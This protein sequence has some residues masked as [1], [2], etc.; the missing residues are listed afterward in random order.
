MAGAAAPEDAVELLRALIRTACVNDGTPESGQEI[1]GV[2]VLQEYLGDLP[3]HVDVEVVE[4]AP[5]RANLIARLRGT[6][7][8][9][10]S[11]ALVGH[12]DVVPADPAGWR[13]DPFGAE[14]I[15]GEIWG[16]GAVDMLNLT[17]AMAVAFKMLA[18]SATRL[19]GDLVLAATAD[20]EAGSRYG[21]G[22]LVANRPD[23]V[24]TDAA[25]TE[26]GGGIPLGSE[27]SRR[28]TITTGQKGAAVRRV[29]LRGTSGHGSM[30][31]GIV[32]GTMLAADV[33]S[34]LAAHRT[35]PVI[36]TG[37]WWPGLL[38]SLELAPDLIERLCD[39]TTLD[40][41]LPETGEI[42]RVLHAL[43]H[44]TVSPNVVASGSK[45]NVI[46][47]EATVDLDIRLLPGQTGEDA[48]R[49]LAAALHGL[50]AGFT[51]DAGHEAPALETDRDDPLYRVLCD[52][53]DEFHP[54][55]EP[56]PLLT[57]GGNDARHYLARGLPCY[58]F[59]MFS[60]EMD[61]ATFRARFHG[62]DE[63]IDVD[64]VHLA[65]AAYR[66]IAER[67]LAP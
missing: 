38:T 27:T 35:A 21:M 47:G 48:D 40:D 23:L 19:R 34:R 42:A 58:G 14:I 50:D 12:L 36:P 24:L 30:P 20:E 60:A 57:P 49:E 65:A 16:R 18:E 13:H 44:L 54:G 64:S 7:A 43:T 8:G 17:A 41:A 62:D 52:V 26:S 55:A 45:T 10:P 25:L 15:D 32:S 33:I 56:L 31:Y 63:R 46:P 53:I 22:W 28:V 51:I 3:E 37:D 66:R 5:G 2:R 1:R 6:D 39:P 61:I 59:G 9:A 11:L 67:F 4:P 29:T